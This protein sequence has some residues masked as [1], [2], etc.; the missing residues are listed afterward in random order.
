MK[1]MKRITALAALCALLLAGCGGPSG[2]AGLPAG[3]EEDWTLV[4]DLLGVEPMEGFVLGE[5]KDALGAA[6]LY[7]ATWTAGEGE[8]VTNDEDEEAT[9][10]DAQLYVLIQQYKETG[11]AEAA[12][13]DWQGRERENYESGE[14]VTGT[15]A[16]QEFTLLPLLKGKEG[17][18]YTHG[19]AAFALHEGGWAICV[20]LLCRDRFGGEPEAILADFLDG[21]HYNDG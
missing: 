12:L 5:N 20:E 16:G 19:A 7:Y 2:P 10:Y 11:K 4:G 3:W 6:G 15:H 1:I 13:E 17:N 8:S 18:P 14:A 9:V 21:F